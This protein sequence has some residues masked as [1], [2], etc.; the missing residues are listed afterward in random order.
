MRAFHSIAT[1]VITLQQKQQEQLVTMLRALEDGV[2]EKMKGEVNVLNM[3][4]YIK[5]IQD[6]LNCLE[7]NSS[8][9]TNC[10]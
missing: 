9:T 1:K 7:V 2:A 4:P 10:I 5:T 3:S 6:S 8:T